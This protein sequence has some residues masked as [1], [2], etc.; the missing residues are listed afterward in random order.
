MNTIFFTEIYLFMDL[1]FWMTLQCNRCLDRQCVH[2]CRE[3]ESKKLENYKEKRQNFTYLH[4]QIKKK[5]TY[6]ILIV[7]P[8]NFHT[9]V[10][11]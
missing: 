9:Y 11:I 6:C 5:N 8:E 10:G 1:L 7:G 2:M 3:S 4:S